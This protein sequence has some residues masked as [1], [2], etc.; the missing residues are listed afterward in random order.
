MVPFKDVE[1][2]STPILEVPECLL[3]IRSILGQD[4]LIPEPEQVVV[5]ELS[6]LLIFDYFSFRV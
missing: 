2:V 3:D 1:P 4:Y 6:D 5:L